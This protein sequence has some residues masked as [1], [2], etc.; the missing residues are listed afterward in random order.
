MVGPAMNK[1]DLPC[2]RLD[3]LSALAGGLAAC[4]MLLCTP[5]LSQ[6]PAPSPAAEEPGMFRAIGNWFKR[7]AEE[8]NANFKDAG[9]RFDNL[10][11]EAGVAARNT[12]DGARDAA[13]AVARLPKTRVVSGHEKCRL[14]ANGAPDCLAAADAV[15]KTKGFGSGKS[16]DMTTAEVC[17]PKVWMSGRTT[18]EGCHTETFVSRALC[19]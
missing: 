3:R 6:A 2:R 7:Q 1:R 18:G 14:A 10:G 4:A 9:R 11:R 15:C 5:A 16:V 12:V 17:P 19:Q 13:D 8:I